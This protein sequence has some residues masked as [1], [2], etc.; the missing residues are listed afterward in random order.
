VEGL[1]ALW[2]EEQLRLRGEPPPDPPSPR[3]KS[4]DVC[5][6]VTA[7]SVEILRALSEVRCTTQQT[8]A[9]ADDG[10]LVESLAALWLAEG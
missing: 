9:A 5:A 10:L 8:A 6:I 3:R 1:S 7:A 2:P 4:Q